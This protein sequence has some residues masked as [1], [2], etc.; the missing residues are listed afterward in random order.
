MRTNRSSCFELWREGLSRLCFSLALTASVC[1]VVA[2]CSSAPTGLVSWWSGD[3][4]AKDIA[5]G[6]NGSLQGGGTTSSAGLVGQAFGFDGTNGFVEVPDAASLRPTNLTVEAWVRFSSLDSAGNSSSGDQYIVFRQNSSTNSGTFEGFALMKARGTNGDTFVFEVSNPFGQ[7][8]VVSSVTVVGAGLW[9]HVAGVR[10]PDF[11]QLYVN[12]QLEGQT[13]VSFAQDY[14]NWPLYFGTTGQ[15]AWD[16]KFAGWL[17]EVCLYNRTLSA[18]EINGIYIAGA[19]GKCKGVIL[20]VQPQDR[21]VLVGSNAFFSVSATG[22]GA[23]SYQWH[24]NGVALPAATGTGLAL[25]NV[26]PAN[27]GNYTV[28]VNNSLGA[29]TSAVAVLTVWVPPIIFDSNQPVSLIVEAGVTARFTVI[30]SG[31]QPLSYQW[32]QGGVALVD[33]GH[34]SGGSSGSLLISCVGVQDAGSY[35]VSVS[36]LAGVVTSATATLAV[37]QMVVMPDPQ[38]EAAVLCALS[39][40]NCD[41]IN[42][43]DLRAL[44]RLSANDYG[45]TN[46]SGL[47]WAS[48]LRDLFLSGNAISDLSP[49]QQLPQLTHLNLERNSIGDVSPLAGL[50]NLSSLVLNGN[51]IQD[52]SPLAG[53]SHLSS[54]SIHDAGLTN[55]AFVQNLSRL[56]ELNLFNNRVV[57]ISAL[58]GLT[59]LSLLDLRWDPITNHAVVSGMTGMVNLE[60]RDNS[61]S[62]L[63][64]VS[65]LGRLSY[66]DLAYNDVRDLSALV[67]RTNLSLVLDGNT[68]LDYTTLSSLTNV[69]RVWLNDNAISNVA[70]LQ[71]LPQLRALGLE[72]NSIADFSPL[73]ALTQLTHLG[74]SRNPALNAGLVARLTNL[75]SLRLEGSSITNASFLTNLPQLAFL[76]LNGNLVADLSPLSSLNNLSS[77]YLSHNRLT[78]I[79]ALMPLSQLRFVDVSRGL[80][81]SGNGSTAGA[82]LENLRCQAVNVTYLPTNQLT[83]SM[84]FPTFPDWYIPTTRSSWLGFYVSDQVAPANELL[85]EVSSSA[86]GV[87]PNSGLSLGGTNNDRTLTVTPATAG[88]VTNTLTVMDAPGGLST[89][90][91]IITHVL[92][93]DP[94]FAIPDAA[95]SNSISGALGRTGGD[96]TSVDLLELTSLSVSDQ[97][98][99]DLSGLQWATNLSRLYLLSSSVSNL[100]AL[101]ALTNLTLLSLSSNLVT[102]ISPLA[103]LTNLSYLDLGSNPVTNY[104]ALAALTNLTTLLLE[105]NS[106]SDLNFLTNLTELVTLDL[107]INKITD[108]SPLIGLT[109][110]NTLLLKQNLLIDLGALTNLSQLQYVDLRLNLIDVSTNTVIELL[111]GQNTLVDDMPQRSAP[112]IDVRTNW[113]IASQTASSL[114][115]NIWDTGPTDQHFGVGVNSASAD[116]ACS[117]SPGSGQG[118]WTLTVTPTLVTTG[119]NSITLAATNDVGYSARTTILVVVTDVLP[120][121]GQ[122]LGD[123]GATWSSGGDAPW[124]GQGLVTHSGHPVAQSGAIGNNQGSFMRTTVVGPGRLSF[125]WKVSSE[126]NA[127]WLEF[128]M[129]GQVNRLTGEVDWKQQI[130]QVPPGIQTLTWR[131]YKN[132]TT[133]RSLDAGWLDQVSFELGTWVIT[134]P[135]QTNR[136]INELTTLTVTNGAVASNVPADLLGYQLIDPPIGAIIDDNGVI[137]WTPSEEQ[138]PST[139]VIM[140]IVSAIGV[141]S[142]NATNSFT[143]VVN[144]VNVTPVLPLI[145][146]QVVNE[147][148]LLV[149]TNTAIE[150][151]IHASLVY[152][153]LNAPLGASIN[154]NG[155]IAWMPPHTQSP[156]TSLIT[157]AVTGI[158]RFDLVNPQLSATNSFMVV[159]NP[160]SIRLE[161]PTVSSNGALRFRVL[162]PDGRQCA[163]QIST[164][165]AFWST[166]QTNTLTGGFFYFTEPTQPSMSLQCFFR[167]ILLPVTHHRLPEAPPN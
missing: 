85:V 118:G 83:L 166:M 153:L 59:N 53:L 21:T 66:V 89:S 88:I 141:P 19:A 29:V 45:I 3:G 30:A 55:V 36:N 74:L 101:R 9:Y 86:Q 25:S 78:N 77:L 160:I 90:T 100:T 5:G 73:T 37:T 27:S 130:A 1:S 126:T 84:A 163:I 131:Y 40:T 26:Q 99:V 155:I 72:N 2:D 71:N 107:D 105:G 149:V 11:L 69:S 109:N 158:D 98:I 56:T 115:F 138:A 119:T 13:N 14:G 142:L 39:K 128:D 87:I 41:L 150:S 6:S 49:L 167:A 129:A 111:R 33:D 52:C 20:T 104:A 97:G 124:F 159:V 23:L 31:T 79:A 10:G 16:H 103:V 82:V 145:P 127:D 156:V 132:S 117:L 64:F 18:G 135:P 70:F 80:F 113:V 95:L 12:G 65:G 17:D 92:L 63:T 133:S 7:T 94:N 157:T 120:V 136:A 114:F 48:N 32:R 122:L 125:W 108:V 121:D 15:S 137:N 68:N 76:S 91:H 34:I 140:T 47:E 44:T 162:G 139:N 154:T 38:L 24:F 51:P 75:T 43:V 42:S 123:P 165:L 60:L 161:S 28:T 61:I 143:V 112:T 22:F 146:L 106:I 151:N 144:E 50:T 164:N 54:L 81:A 46:L 93:P 62:N 58:G 35:S 4:D 147:L 116:W 96:L 8:A 57:D 134:L 110:L 148:T 67:G 152:R 102:D